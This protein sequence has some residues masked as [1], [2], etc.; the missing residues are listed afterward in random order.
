M[1]SQAV[2]LPDD[3]AAIAFVYQEARI[4]DEQRFDDWYDLFTEDSIYWMPLTR[5]QPDGLN[6][7]SL[8]Y[9]DKLL[10]KVRIERLKSPR[11]Y[12]QGV[13][14]YCHHVLQQPMVEQRTNDTLI[15]RTP[16]LYVETQ[17]DDQQV[18]GATAFHHLILQDGQIRMKH[19][20]VELV[21]PDAGFGSI[22][23]FL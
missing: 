22:Q 16:F 7:N 13:R 5:N 4:I 10:L 6:H 14:S 18:L 20:K 2:L 19:K 3:A 8:F 1:T 17:G 21:N 23:L 15:I 11:S 12:S 9:E